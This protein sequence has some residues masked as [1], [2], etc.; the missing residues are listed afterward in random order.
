MEEKYQR[1]T[2]TDEEKKGK[3]KKRGPCP[4]KRAEKE[5]FERTKLRYKKNMLSTQNWGGEPHMK[6]PA[7][8][9]KTK[10]ELNVG[11]EK[12]GGV[13]HMGNQFSLT[14]GGEAGAQFTG[15]K[16]VRGK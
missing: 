8:A 12:G 11:R 9:G 2:G 14:G 1:K 15:G 3:K 5:T 13:E 7:Q 16:K 10:Q 6:K 4:P